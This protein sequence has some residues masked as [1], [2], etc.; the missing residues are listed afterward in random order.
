MS[1]ANLFG[2]EAELCFPDENPLQ[3]REAPSGPSAFLPWIYRARGPQGCWHTP[4]GRTEP[5]SS[6]YLPGQISLSSRETSRR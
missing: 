4:V 2:Q 3:P 1:V 6:T 5:L